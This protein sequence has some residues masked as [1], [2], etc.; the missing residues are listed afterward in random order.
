MMRLR[1]PLFLLVFLLV[2]LPPPLYLTSLFCLSSNDIAGAVVLAGG[3]CPNSNFS[4]S[5]DCTDCVPD[6]WGASCQFSCP[7][8]YVPFNCSFGVNGT[9][10]CVGTPYNSPGYPN[11]WTPPIV[12]TVV[13]AG[14]VISVGILGVLCTC[15][16]RSCRKRSKGNG[17]NDRA[18]KHR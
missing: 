12:V 8:C 14:F 13:V 5:S 3:V 11:A 18:R 4:S 9:G 1:P 10:L 15:L 16:C 17:R 7:T 6:R 2:L